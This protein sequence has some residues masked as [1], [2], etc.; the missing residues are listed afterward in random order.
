M[1]GG[2][3]SSRRTVY[4]DGTCADEGEYD[5]TINVREDLLCSSCPFIK[6][7]LVLT[8]GCVRYR[9]LGATAF[10]AVMVQEVTASSTELR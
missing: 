7:A 3:Y 2:P 6:L 9:T 8:C 10:A 4:S 5:F 1:S